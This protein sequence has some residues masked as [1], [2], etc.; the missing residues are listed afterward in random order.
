[1]KNLFIQ[2]IENSLVINSFA[3]QCFVTKLIQSM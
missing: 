2:K 1:M 3:V